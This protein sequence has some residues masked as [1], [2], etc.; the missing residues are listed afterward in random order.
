VEDNGAGFE[1]AQA[2]TENT[3]LGLINMKNI[4]QSFGGRFILDSK[5]G[6]GTAIRVEIPDVQFVSQ[7]Q[8]GI[9]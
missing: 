2:R 3:G 7:K 6:R 1:P 9:A 5:S 8:G 4:V